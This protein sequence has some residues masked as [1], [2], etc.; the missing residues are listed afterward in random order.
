MVKMVRTSK[1]QYV[2]VRTFSKVQRQVV[3][4][5]CGNGGND[6]KE[7]GF[8]FHFQTFQELLECRD[9][10]QDEIEEAFHRLG[11]IEMAEAWI[12]SKTAVLSTDYKRDTR[13]FVRI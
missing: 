12:I 9:T 1:L 3:E 11:E 13:F 7:S 8:I 10:M 2:F 6:T 5:I 4:Y